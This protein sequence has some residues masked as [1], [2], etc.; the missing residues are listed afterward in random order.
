M[1][2]QGK[3]KVLDKKAFEW[4]LAVVQKTVNAKRNIALLYCSFGLGLRAKELASLRLSDVLDYDGQLLYEVNLMRHMT[5]GNKQRTIYLNNKKLRKALEDYIAERNA[6][7]KGF[8]LDRDIP[9]FKSQKGGAF[10]PNAMQ[11]VFAKFYRDSG[12]LGASSHS[13]RRTFATNL[14]DNGAS[15][16]AVQKLMGHSSIKMTAEYIED[17][18]NK[19]KK[20]AEGAL[21]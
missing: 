18:P 9:L 10:S 21:W 7:M 1:P 17:N 5:K 2:R 15:L 12:I 6:E 4:T 11:Q 14:D 19:L 13:G 3:A 20:I 8:K 16:K